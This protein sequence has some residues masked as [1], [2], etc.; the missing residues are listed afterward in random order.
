MADGEE[1]LTI[2]NYKVEIDGIGVGFKEV[3]GLSIEYATISYSESPVARGSSGP[4][5]INMPGQRKT[6]EAITLLKGIV[7]MDTFQT[8]YAWIN[9]IQGTRVIKKDIFIRLC[10]AD[11]EAV[12]SWK[13]INAFPI[14]LEAPKFEAAGEEVAIETM[15]LMA[16][17]IVVEAA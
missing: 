9:S 2:G 11:G 5:K 14:A 6:P 15:K 10:D 16:D 8:M 3:S 1:P 17:R 12:V 4:R 7:G 13:V